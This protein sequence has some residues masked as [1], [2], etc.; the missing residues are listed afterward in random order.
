MLLAA[1]GAVS[2]LESVCISCAQGGGEFLELEQIGGRDN[3]V[4]NMTVFRVRKLVH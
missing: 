1:D 3:L 2:D 4:R